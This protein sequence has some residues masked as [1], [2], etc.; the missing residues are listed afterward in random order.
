M[1]RDCDVLKKGASREGKR[2]TSRIL[3]SFNI[4]W[5]GRSKPGLRPRL[6]TNYPIRRSFKLSHYSLIS[7]L[8]RLWSTRSKKKKKFFCDFSKSEWPKRCPD[9]NKISSNFFFNKSLSNNFKHSIASGVTWLTHHFLL[10]NRLTLVK[11]I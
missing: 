7:K 6:L 2:G 4:S 8:C 10:L 1:S 9:H 11:K 5:R 3:Q